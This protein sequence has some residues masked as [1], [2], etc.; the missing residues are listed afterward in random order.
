MNE[1]DPRNDADHITD[2][3]DISRTRDEDVVGSSSDDDFEDVDAIDES[4]E[5]LED[6][7]E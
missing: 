2:E 5:D 1:R 7:D 4:D 3:P 6:L